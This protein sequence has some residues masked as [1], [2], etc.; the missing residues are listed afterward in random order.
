MILYSGRSLY[1]AK[2]FA[3]N[4]KFIRNYLNLFQKEHHFAGFHT[5]KAAYY[6]SKKFKS[7]RILV[8][9]NRLLLF[10]GFLFIPNFS[11]ARSYTLDELL[12]LSLKNS[13]KLQIIESDVGLLDRKISETYSTMLPQV[14]FSAGYFHSFTPGNSFNAINFVNSNTSLSENTTQAF[15]NYSSTAVELEPNFAVSNRAPSTWTTGLN[16]VQPIY[17][18]GKPNLELK[19]LKIYQRALVCKIQSQKQQIKA[20]IMKAFYAALVAQK[21]HEVKILA[22]NH[23]Y[24]SHLQAVNKFTQGKA[25]ELDTLESLLYYENSKGDSV[26]SKIDLQN[27]YGSLII[28]SGLN[29]YNETAETFNLQGELVEFE[30]NMD[31]KQVLEIVKRENFTLTQMASEQNVKELNVSYEKSAYFPM[32][33]FGAILGKVY[34]FNTFHFDEF[35]DARTTNKSVFVNLHMNLFSGLRSM[36]RVRQAKIQAN[37]SLLNFKVVENDLLLKTSNAY[38]NFVLFKSQLPSSKLKMELAQKVMNVTKVAY[39]AGQRTLGEM[40]KTRIS[41][42]QAQLE[43]LENLLQIQNAIIDIKILLCQI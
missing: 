38:E 13:K 4:L 14:T 42:S 30:F 1:F 12:K 19:I 11:N 43:Y 15:P 32:I 39:D 40:E 27:K 8:N 36:E 7:I 35:Q 22:M 2:C 3:L 37:K 18:Q 41:Y 31:L 10:L 34:Q 5:Q 16:F 33:Y 20:E 24:Q 25:S 28:L 21:R 6:N 29:E 9:M 17:M 23:A 26:K